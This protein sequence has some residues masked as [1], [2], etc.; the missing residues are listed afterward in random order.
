MEKKSSVPILDSRF[1]KV[2]AVK[3]AD[4]K[5]AIVFVCMDG[6]KYGKLSN[7]DRDKL[8]QKIDEIEPTAVYFPLQSAVDLNFYDKGDFKGKN[9][10]VTLDSSVETDT[11]AIEKEIKNVLKMANSIEFVYQPLKIE[12]KK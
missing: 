6:S 7:V 12:V 4:L 5:D 8:V 9:L 3:K 2:L 1:L 10:L 11:D